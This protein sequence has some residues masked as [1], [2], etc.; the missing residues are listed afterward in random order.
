[1]LL[2]EMLWKLLVVV[3]AIASIASYF[4]IVQQDAI[5]GVHLLFSSI[6]L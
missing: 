6:C 4:N 2:L 1:M 5:L 3:M